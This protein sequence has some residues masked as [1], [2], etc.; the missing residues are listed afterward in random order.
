M[1]LD[2]RSG[3]LVMIFRRWFWARKPDHD[4]VSRKVEEAVGRILY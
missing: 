3:K 4:G 2:V 1:S